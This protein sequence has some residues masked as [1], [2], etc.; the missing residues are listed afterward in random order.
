MM[1][2]QAVY[3]CMAARAL[4]KGKKDEG[5][6]LVATSSYCAKAI[7]DDEDDD[8]VNEEEEDRVRTPARQRW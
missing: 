4:E 5:H 7:E 6:G 8:E 1:M 3:A 2:K